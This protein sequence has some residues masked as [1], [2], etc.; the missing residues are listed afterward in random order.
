M[1]PAGP[2]GLLTTNEEVWCSRRSFAAARAGLVL[3]DRHDVAVHDVIHA[4]GRTLP[5]VL[6]PVYRRR[7]ARYATWHMLDN[8]T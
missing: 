3:S 6:V 1:M 4:H 7:A 8:C 2:A 5:V